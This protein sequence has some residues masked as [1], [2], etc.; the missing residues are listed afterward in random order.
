VVRL[1]T[2]GVFV[3]VLSSAPLASAQ[4]PKS[5]EGERFL[6]AAGAAQ[7][8]RP[9]RRG[10]VVILSA[11]DLPPETADG[12]TELVL[13]AVASQ[14]SWVLVGKEEFQARLG[15]SEADTLECVTSAACL[16]R[17]GVELHLDEII[18][19]TVSQH[20]GLWSFNINR[21]D[22]SS[23]EVTARVFR[24]V[25]GGLGAVA[26]AMG[27]AVPRLFDEA[28][29]ESGSREQEDAHDPPPASVS[30]ALPPAVGAVE[31]SLDG[32]VV[33]AS[34]AHVIRL[35]E[36]EPGR[37][38]L[39]VR[40]PG[41]APWERGLRLSPGQ[42]LELAAELQ[43]ESPDDVA[44][45]ARVSPMLW[46]G[47]SVAVAAAGAGIGLGVASQRALGSMETRVEAQRSLDRRERQAKTAN[48]LFGVAA[49]GAVTAA[50]GALWTDWKALRG[51]RR[52]TW[53]VEIV[54][55][56]GGASV[57]VGGAL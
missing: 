36:V 21:V 5:P 28:S 44:P 16:G 31:V 35:P 40:A 10:A 39:V 20:E 42:V 51:E 24:R 53:K 9:S 46:A 48:A 25:P 45:P 34:D 26:R 56:Q 7:A 43:P 22:V 12:L 11:G 30:I 23:G 19:G 32:A 6:Q 33:E 4:H 29:E 18:A 57:R 47:A 54:P 2:A 41:Y 49:A 27:N 17:A 38:R 37:H 14:G 3:V 55:R 52:T 50:L 1:A 13:G 15:R 8:P